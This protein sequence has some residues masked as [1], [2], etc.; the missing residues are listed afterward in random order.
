M[1][2][3]RTIGGKERRLQLLS[4]DDLMSITET[5]P[6]PS[7][8]IVDLRGLDLWSKNPRGCEWFLWTSAAKLEPT[9]KR[10][11]VAAWGSLL[12][13]INN[14]SEVFQLSITTGEESPVP[15]G[16]GATGSPP[17]GK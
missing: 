11:D 15:K 2:I 16:E 17:I 3:T 6:R 13:R 1:T 5:I 12:E 9:L 14:A 10:E 7:G 4:V 8:E